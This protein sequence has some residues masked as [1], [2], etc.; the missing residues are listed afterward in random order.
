MV[1]VSARFCIILGQYDTLVL[2]FPL[3]SG[4]GIKC[5][6]FRIL[7]LKMIHVLQIRF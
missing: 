6:V 1:Q 7:S 5:K 4:A 2:Y 3:K